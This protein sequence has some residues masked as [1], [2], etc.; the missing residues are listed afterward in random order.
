MIETSSVRCLYN[1]LQDANNLLSR[2]KDKDEKIALVN[3][4][5]S[6]YYSIECVSAMKA[7]ASRMKVFRNKRGYHKFT[8]GFNLYK[9]KMLENFVYYKDFHS[10]FLGDLLLAVEDNINIFE[11]TLLEATSL[12]EEDFYAIFF[13]FMK[14]YHLEK[15]FD[16]F[17]RERRIYKMVGDYGH[18]IGVTLFNPLNKD[19]D[20]FV[21]DS[22]YNINYLFTLAHEFGLIV[23]LIFKVMPLH[24]IV[25]F[26]NLFM[27]K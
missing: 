5:L 26:I 1:R 2:S 3:Y 7:N 17:I 22:A 24:I 12:S 23:L 10:S 16:K 9:L 19:C 4:I 25:T 6:M 13:G 27:K 20:I 11:G 21:K 15:L 18:D 8:R 14:H